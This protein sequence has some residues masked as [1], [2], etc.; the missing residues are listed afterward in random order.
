MPIPPGSLVSWPTASPSSSAPGSSLSWRSRRTLGGQSQLHLGLVHGHEE[1]Y[2]LSIV[3][4]VKARDCY[5]A[6]AVA[7]QSRAGEIE[8]SSL[9]EPCEQP[10]PAWLGG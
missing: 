9:P 8:A 10:A 3:A 7:A 1:R 4:F 5:D 2:E 6:A